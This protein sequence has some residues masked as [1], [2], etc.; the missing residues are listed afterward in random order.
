LTLAPAS[1]NAHR[2]FYQLS[3]RAQSRVR[4]HRKL[5][6]AER[7]VV[8]SGP[9]THHGRCQRKQSVPRFELFEQP[10]HDPAHAVLRA[11]WH[12][13]RVEHAVLSFVQRALNLTHRYDTQIAAIGI[14][15]LRA[16]QSPAAD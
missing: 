2:S 9:I 8:I 7:P 11:G 15:G 16:P 14:E 12:V 6:D 4:E 10:R 3:R 5:V 1:A 13:G